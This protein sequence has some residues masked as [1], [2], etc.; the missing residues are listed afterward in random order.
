MV[1]LTASKRSK[2]P[3]KDFAGPGRT[4]PDQ[5]RGH[6]IAAKGRAKQ[7]ENRGALSEH[8]YESIVRKAD[9]KLK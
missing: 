9:K 5:D 4:Y 3:T 6:A 2:F 8:A 1:K 7:Q